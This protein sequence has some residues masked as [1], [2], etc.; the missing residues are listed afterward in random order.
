MRIA[1][2]LILIAVFTFVV[3]FV[4][5]QI[6]LI[7]AKQYTSEIIDNYMDMYRIMQN[8]VLFDEISD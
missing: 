8:E 4:F 3:Q 6:K 2:G 5:S 1:F 7:Q